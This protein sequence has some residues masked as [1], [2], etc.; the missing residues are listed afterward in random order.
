MNLQQSQLRASL[1]S[2]RA[3]GAGG[4]RTHCDSNI[5]NRPWGDPDEESWM[6]TTMCQASRAVEFRGGVGVV[7]QDSLDVAWSKNC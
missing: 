7:V 1:L 2:P 6:A 3:G 5:G 4:G